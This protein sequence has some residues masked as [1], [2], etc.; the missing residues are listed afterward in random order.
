M[1]V[2]GCICLREVVEVATDCLERQNR[3]RESMSDRDKVLVF[4]VTAEMLVCVASRPKFVTH[5]SP[6]ASP[7]FLISYLE[8]RLILL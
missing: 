7:I 8:E 5:N 2:Q 6:D 4:N 1:S 3:V